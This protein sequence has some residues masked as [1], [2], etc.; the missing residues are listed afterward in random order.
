MTDISIVVPVLN[1]EGSLNE[2]YRRLVEVMDQLGRSYEMIFVDDGSRDESLEILRS[3]FESDPRVKV[4][5]F[6]R[7]YGKS[8]ALAVGFE[9]ASGGTIVTIDADLQDDPRE[10]PAL[11]SALDRGY[12]L[13]S[14]WKKRRNDPISKTLPSKIFN[15]VT[16]WATGVKLHDINSGLKAYRREVTDEIK[17][18]GELHRFL[19]VFAHKESFRVGEIPVAHHPRKFGKT[20]YGAR[21]FLHG[22]LDLLTVIMITGYTRSPLHFFGTIG[23]FL[24]LV[25]VC[26]NSVLVY[27]KVKYGNI[28]GRTP[29]LMLGVLLM[30]LG[31]QLVSTGLLAELITRAGHKGRKEY[32]LKARFSHGETEQARGAEE[33]S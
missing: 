17:L 20:K 31:F 16:S 6:R 23:I 7:H 12:D 1:E 13:V 30:I 26:I 18:Y 22:F 10:I 9:E 11:L 33:A 24:T 2:L 27:F 3:I 29:L 4:L 19:P 14:G 15:T 32:S 28:Q 25:G 8:A 5:S 21:R